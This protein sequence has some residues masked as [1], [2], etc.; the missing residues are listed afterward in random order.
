M[1]CLI[2]RRW[3]WLLNFV[4]WKNTHCWMRLPRVAAGVSSLSL[5]PLRLHVV[6]VTLVAPPSGGDAVTG[7][8][9]RFGCEVSPQLGEITM[10]ELVACGLERDLIGWLYI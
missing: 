4:S 5:K 9:T 7:L 2:V 10:H 1:W 8:V 3:S 6:I